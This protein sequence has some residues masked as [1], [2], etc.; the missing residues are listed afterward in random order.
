M[1]N[2]W[3]G[4]RAVGLLNAA[5]FEKILAKPGAHFFSTYCFKKRM[6]II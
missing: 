1:T 4:S 3:P 6:Q 5:I 2:M